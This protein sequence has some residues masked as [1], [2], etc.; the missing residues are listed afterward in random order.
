MGWKVKKGNLWQK[1]E[2]YIV[3]TFLYSSGTSYIQQRLVMMILSVICFNILSDLQKFDALKNPEV[4]EF[5]GKMKA[6]CD[7]V[8]AS[9][10]KLTW[11]ERVKSYILLN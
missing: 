5:R 2:F 4:N 6:L 10:N 9:R 1:S 11:S 7:E 8:V 3:S